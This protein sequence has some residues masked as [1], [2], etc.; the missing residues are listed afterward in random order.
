[1]CRDQPGNCRQ[2]SGHREHPAVSADAQVLE[3]KTSCVEATG[4]TLFGHKLLRAR[5][6]VSQ[7]FFLACVLSGPDRRVESKR[8]QA[9]QQQQNHRPEL[10]KVDPS[11]GDMSQSPDHWRNSHI[12]KATSSLELTPIKTSSHSLML[13]SC[14]FVE[15]F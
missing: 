6:R 11:E 3:R 12:L 15:L 1:M 8:D 13:S 14:S 2:S 4:E 7:R 9:R 5:Y 10:T